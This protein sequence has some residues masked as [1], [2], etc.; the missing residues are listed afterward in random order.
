M[1]IISILKD[2]Q[3]CKTSPTPELHYKKK[4]VELLFFFPFYV[5]GVISQPAMLVRLLNTSS[6]L[7]FF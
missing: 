3:M 6:A 7:Y 1:G 2:T 4:E 5:R